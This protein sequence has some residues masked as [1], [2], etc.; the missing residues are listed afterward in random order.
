MS[1]ILSKSAL[2]TINKMGDIML[3]RTTEFPSFSETGCIEHI[4]DIIMYTPKEDLS[5]LNTILGILS[6]FPNSFLKMMVR[7]MQSSH[8]KNGGLSFIFRQLD[9]GL[10]GI[11]F[12]CYYSGKT[13]KSFQGKNPHD[14]IGYKI[15]RI[16]D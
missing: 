4:D 3:P 8:S 2:R 14:I 5:G 10:K 9:F 15:N 7:N 16:T 1:K 13:G 11:I 6:V 12:T